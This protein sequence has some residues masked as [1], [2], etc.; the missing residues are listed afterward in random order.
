MTSFC[1]VKGFE[2][3]GLAKVISRS[4]NVCTV[5]YFDSPR[6]AGQIKREATIGAISPKKL[7]RNSRVYVYSP[8]ED[9]WRV[10]RVLEDDGEGILVRLAHKQDVY[11]EYEHVFVRWKRG[12]DDPSD[13]LGCQ[14]TETPQYAEARSRFLESYIS[15]RG[16]A[17]G[18]SSLLSS[19]VELEPHQIDVVGR[20]LNDPSQRYLLADEVG[21]GK[22]IEAG[23][24]I[25]QAVLDDPANHRVAIVVPVALVAQ[26]RRELLARFGLQAFLDISV[27]V[28]AQEEDDHLVE[29]LD[30]AT[31]IV[32]DEAHHMAAANAD[33]SVLRLYELIRQAALR[34]S[35]LLLLSATPI[36]RNEDGFLRMLHLLEP[37]VYRLDER[38]SFR[39]KIEHRQSLAETVAMLEPSHA[40]F[41]DGLLDDLLAK[42]PN[43]IRLSDLATDLRAQL[44]GD[45][46]E[47]DPG[48][49]D[50]LRNLR[51]HVSETYRLN[52][53]ILRNRRRQVSGLT[54]ERKGLESW[55]VGGSS[56]R[57]LESAI[58]AWRIAANASLSKSSDA[59]QLSSMHRFYEGLVDGVLEDLNFARQSCIRRRDKL[60]KTGNAAEA[61][62]EDELQ[63]LDDILAVCDDREWMDLRL[64]ALAENLRRLPASV[65]A[66]VFCSS[67]QVAD[68][69]SEHLRRENL[70]A[71]RHQSGY[72][73]DDHLN[74]DQDPD[75]RRFMASDAIGVLVCDRDAEEGINL[76]GG[77]KVIVHFDLPLQPNRVEQRIG[78]VDRYGSGMPV[79]SYALVDVAS[80][81]QSKWV[82]TLREGW[83]VFDRSL[84]S[85]QY[86][87]EAE[88]SNL[89]ESLLLEGVEAISEL[90]GRLR[91]P[92]G[93]VNSE[94]KLIDQQ[95][96]LDELTAM[97][98]DEVE[99]LLDCDSEWNSI[100]DAMHYW[101]KETLLFS[102]IPEET[103]KQLV[104]V[105]SRFQYCPPERGGQATLI[106][107]S[108][109][110]DQFLGAI[111][112]EAPGGTSSRPRSY[113][114]AAHRGT[115]VKGGIRPLRYGDEFVEAIKSFSDSDD[116]GRSFAMWRQIHTGLPGR[117]LQ[118][119]FRFGF[120]IEARIDEAEHILTQEKTVPT[121]VA[122]R[123]VLRRRGDALF[124]P[125]TF[126]VWVDEE[127]DM[128][129]PEFTDMYLDVPYAKNGADNYIDKNIESSHFDALRA[130]RPDLFD[131]WSQRCSRVRDHAFEIAKNSPLLF[132]RKRLALE[133]AKDEDRGRY[134]QL[135]TRINALTGSESR[136]EQA[137]LTLEQHLNDALYAGIATPTIKVDVAGVIFLSSEPVSVIEH[138]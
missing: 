85:L 104:E 65:K 10:G 14:I 5:Q 80:K 9:L 71:L 49:V 59:K 35:R 22:T 11:L 13:F 67:K 134:A 1:V 92:N 29:A 37:A 68:E 33:E 66:I 105:P 86:V 18:I 27:F 3:D 78:R 20:V 55:V 64:V 127:G 117:R 77:N 95:D 15:Q 81:L 24:I 121:S 120:L 126:K 93:I 112:Y 123:A 4:G 8:S 82:E 101:I 125:F 23:I 48:L 51:A 70:R 113:P 90:L 132:D 76:Q 39:T 116:R 34:A 111:D 89:R 19:A 97:R 25:R 28:V 130:S 32:V 44:V 47:S 119:F 129:S 88:S 133:T 128:P 138:A 108:G 73:G 107:L 131:N 96:A 83:R 41:L 91:G 106:P 63:Y 7:G 110:L 102:V 135:A 60:C 124:Q 100:R 58:E 38:E 118:M 45:P 109:F 98:E 43:D 84:S 17:K 79:R 136:A 75:W 72:E 57:A 50:A 21:L 87:V 46:D 114:H 74:L 115:A 94:L 36:L 42:L 62:F 52:R 40:L 99:A 137:R 30:G 103:K 61:I 31:L 69:V 6:G 12:I 16:A 54:P 2:S 26:W 122:D 53:R 56:I